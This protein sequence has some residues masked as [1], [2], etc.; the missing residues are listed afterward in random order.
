MN[1]SKQSQFE[2]IFRKCF[3]LAKSLKNVTNFDLRKMHAVAWLTLRGMQS[4]EYD[5]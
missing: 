2:S 3:E 4:S 1:F 5:S